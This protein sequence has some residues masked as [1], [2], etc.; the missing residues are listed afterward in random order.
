M[1][2]NLLMSAVLV[3]ALTPARAELRVG[4]NADTLRGLTVQNAVFAPVEAVPTF[5]VVK[6]SVDAGQV[7]NE[8]R[9][10]VIAERNR[11]F[12][13]AALS[14][15]YVHHY[16]FPAPGY[17]IAAAIAWDIENVNLSP[18]FVI[19]RNRNFENEGSKYHAEQITIDKAFQAV[20]NWLRLPDSFLKPEVKAVFSKKLAKT[21]LYTTLEPCPQ[22]HSTILM[23]G[24]PEATYCMVDPGLRDAR[25]HR[26]LTDPDYVMTNRAYGYKY[27]GGPSALPLCVAADAQMWKDTVVWQDQHHPQWGHYGYFSITDYIRDQGP[28]MYRPAYEALSNY[29][30]PYSENQELVANLKKTVG[31]PP[32]AR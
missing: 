31:Q 20:A 15:A 1:I 2:R 7:S 18:A 19:N 3:L 6:V 24:I 28:V 17:D 8:R 14:Y 10:E 32:A 22:C 21:H 29:V 16:D 23:A 13:L 11:L 9:A 26:P 5:E 12:M 30:S 27:S 4:I 25:T